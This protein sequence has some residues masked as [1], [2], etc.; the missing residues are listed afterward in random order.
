MDGRLIKNG[1]TSSKELII[2]TVGFDKGMYIMELSLADGS[3]LSKL[4]NKT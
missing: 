4:I 2:N 1:S 3:K